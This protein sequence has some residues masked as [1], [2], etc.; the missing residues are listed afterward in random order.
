MQAELCKTNRKLW[1][2]ELKKGFSRIKRKCAK[3]KGAG[4][5]KNVIRTYSGGG[6][7]IA[8]EEGKE[9]AKLQWQECDPPVASLNS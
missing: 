9:K 7:S 2:R 5:K 3:Y 6:W 4:R 8:R 1:S